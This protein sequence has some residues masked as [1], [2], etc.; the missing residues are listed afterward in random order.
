MK[1]AL[2]GAGYFG[3]FHIDAWTRAEGATLAAIVD[4]DLSRAEAAGVPGYADAMD[5]MDAVQPD[6]IDIA[7]P[8]PTHLPL[9]EAL[10]PVV[11]NI[12]C[13]KPFCGGL[14]DAER[15]VEVAAANG[16]RVIVHENFR[17]QPW[18]MEAQRLL[19]DGA[20]GEPY[21][22][23]FRL[24]PGDGQGPEAFLARQPYFQQMERFLVHET[25]IHVI[26]VFRA[27]FGEPDG[28]YADLR[29]L[30]PAIKGEDAGLI[31]LD[32]A[33]GRRAVFD[34]NRLADHRAE[35]RRLTMGEME[36]EGAA[37]TLRL[38]GDGDIT[39]RVHGEN[40]ERAHH[41]SWED[42]HFGGDC[43]YIS[44]LKYLDSLRSDEPHPTEAAA[45][46]AN[47]RIVE[48][49]YQS[50]AEGRRISLAQGSENRHRRAR[51]D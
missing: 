23:T 3:Q 5:M 16:A 33:D 18:H 38:N 42:R 27:M 15:A 37:G 41:Y 43:V 10:S 19:A 26:D 45:Y 35:N 1:V 2:I 40:D 17:Y 46:L 28:V 34:G 20:V 9:I 32:Y 12:I 4:P 11:K 51:R 24:R 29:R 13:Q 14:E 21:E 49:A 22:I 47:M 44:S 36:V 6:I 31:I 7:S 8:P 50:A 25:A 39:V 48:A 30:N